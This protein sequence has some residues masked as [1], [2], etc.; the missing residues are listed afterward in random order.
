MEY[1]SEVM[2]RL[3]SE[4]SPEASATNDVLQYRGK[5]VV[6]TGCASG[7]GAA[8]AS[9]LVDLG[10]SVVGLD[11]RP[12]EGV[13]DFIAVDLRS[14]DSIDSAVA[15]IDGPVDAIFSVAGLPGPP[16]SDLD[17]VLVNFVGARHLI[18]A[19][20]PV[21]P[22]GSAIVCVASN[23]GLGWQQEIAELR[24]LT[25]TD[26]FDAAKQWCEANPARIAGGYSISKK[27]INAW[28]ASRAVDMMKRDIRLNCTNPG[29]TDTAMM[30]SFEQQAGKEVIDAFVGPSGRRSTAEEQAWPLVFLNSPRCSYVTGE[31]LHTDGGFLGA[32]VTGRLEVNL[33]P[34]QP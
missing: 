33:P 20:I 17:T 19:L 23:A 26:G 31:A 1:A 12:S 8:T 14:K 22:A 9:I 25:S 11:V 15:A 2:R 21:M 16:F 5:R 27:L 4:L 32:M 6:V 34:P 18:E 30:P 28:V 10:A 24:D 3:F 29:P 7:M 13:T